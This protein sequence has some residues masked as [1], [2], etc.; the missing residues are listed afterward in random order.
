MD[1]LPLDVPADRHSLVAIRSYIEAAAL[2]KQ[3]ILHRFV[4]DGRPINLGRPLTHLKRFSRIEAETV[5]PEQVPLQLIK[6]A[7]EQTD[8]TRA[9]VQ[10]AVA[11]V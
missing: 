7:M 1:G 11:H 8:S 9:Q 10:S 6:S 4:V 2:Q 5:S 3:R